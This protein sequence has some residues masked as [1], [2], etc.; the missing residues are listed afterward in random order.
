ML[1]QLPVTSHGRDT[2]LKKECKCPVSVPDILRI[3]AAGGQVGKEKY[4]RG[5]YRPPDTG[6]CFSK[7]FII[8]FT[9]CCC[10]CL[11]LPRVYYKPKDW[12]GRN[13]KRKSNLSLIELFGVHSVNYPLWRVWKANILIDF[14][15]FFSSLL[16]L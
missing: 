8:Q 12:E 11:E 13:K 1:Q 9:S 2:L 15:F 10:S 16:H 3:F 6:D 5:K 7:V 4:S 14:D